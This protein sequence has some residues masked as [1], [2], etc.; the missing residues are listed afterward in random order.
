LGRS[1]PASPRALFVRSKMLLREGKIEE[2]TALLGNLADIAG[3]ERSLFYEGGYPYTAER[4]VRSAYA[5]SLMKN[6]QYAEALTELILTSPEDAEIVATRILAIPELA[7][8]VESFKKNKEYVDSNEGPREDLFKKVWYHPNFKQ[9]VTQMESLLAQRLARQGD[10]ES[11][12]PHY[13][14]GKKY[15]YSDTPGQTPPTRYLLAD[16]AVAVGKHLK[17]AKDASLPQREQAEHLFEAATIIGD[18]GDWLLGDWCMRAGLGIPEQ[19]E[20]GETLM[21]DDARRRMAETSALCGLQ[22]YYRFMAAD[23]MKQCAALLPDNDVL[24]A[25]ALYLGGTWLKARYPAEADYFYKALVRRNPNLLIAREADKL[26]WF[27]KTFTDV[28]L[29][30]PLP[31]T[32]IRKRTLALI[33]GMILLPALAAIVWAVLKKRRKPGLHDK[34]MSS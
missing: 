18:K 3:E 23:L 7:A 26:R 17:A 16:E 34:E 33:L 2:A 30:T 22:F 27:P 15:L 11:A 5:G 12:A 29:Y 25:R 24:T 21:T 9:T 32:Y 8:A 31:K 10:W 4:T 14:T 13:D 6:G 28:I 19:P 1:D 20:P